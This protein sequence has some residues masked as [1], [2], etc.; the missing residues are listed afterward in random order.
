M[1]TIDTKFVVNAYG[2]SAGGVA[3]HFR[4]LVDGKDAGQASVSATTPTAYTFTTAVEAGQAHK[5]QVYYDNDAYVSGQ[6]RNLYVK[7]IV[8]NGNTMLPTQATYDRYALDGQDTMAGQEGM[9]WEGALNFAT[10]SSYYPAPVV[11]LPPTPTPTTGASTIVVNALG[12]TAGGVNAHFN[13][14]VD[15]VKVGEAT[16]GTT[17]RD[18][19][20]TANATAD[21]A[22]KVQIQYDNDA[23]INGQDRNLL[24]NKITINGHA[25]AP[26]D[27][28][29]TYDKG[30]LDGKDVVAGQSGMWW[31]GTLV[32]GADKTFFPASSGGTT[33]PPAPTPTT[34]SLSVSNV[35]VQ[36]P[37][38]GSATGIAPGYLHTS[39]GQ[40]VDSAGHDV[41]LTGVNWFGAEGYAFVPQGLWIDSYQ[42][43]MDNMK[44]LG[45]NTIRLPWSDA[46]LDGG[47]RMPTGIDYSKNP[48]LVGLNALQVFDKIIQYADK[49]GMKIILD[50]H[51]SDDG[52]SANE[53]G[54]WYTS[55]HPE[56]TMIANWKMLAARYANNSSVIG[57]D[58]H[59]EPHGPA[60]WGDNNTATDWA[61]AAERIG[62]AVQSVNNKLLLFVEGVEQYQGNT[63]WWGGNLDGQ[64][65][66]DV[67]FNTPDQLVYSVHDYPPS[68]AGFGWFN[69]SSYPNNMPA[70]WTSAW[71]RLIQNDQHPVLVGEFGTRLEQY[72]DQQWLPK[73]VQYMDGDWN[74]DGKIDLTNGQ[75]GASWTYWAWS[76]GS[77]D[78]GGILKSDYTVDYNKVNAIKPA[79]FDGATGP[80]STDALFTVKLSAASTTAVSVNYATVDGTAK[81]GSDYTA[82]NGTLTFNPGE[83]T[84]T[85]AVKVLGDSVAEG[86]ETFSL[87]LSAATAATLG[88]DTGVGTI[89]Q[90]ATAAAAQSDVY[91][92]LVAQ[93]APAPTTDAADLLAHTATMSYAADIHHVDVLPDLTE[94]HG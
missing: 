4:L 79:M 71:G 24:V 87:K 84:K 8:V 76:P 29:V 9:W 11:S 70:K 39:G 2:Q 54:L 48:D 53:N 35:T 89:T 40:I 46:M 55:A 38:A 23:Y 82:T 45:F 28:I 93:A 25:V 59:N 27:S 58:L 1:A 83:T 37:A 14:L 64:K 34:P 36:E 52:A 47:G 56:S 3:P 51:R 77:G 68:M 73:L 49:T 92:H 42:H 60:T 10:P 43:H 65:N 19:S 18:Y 66:Y 85:V 50:H 33:T 74:G 63:Y 90:A 57:A 5:V 75:Q 88:T 41:K 94:Y 13:V 80:G 81:A 31:G 22:H 26:T 44:S 91:T 20:F 32:V 7:S 30:A 15:G 16:A 61:H 67:H 6:D 69:D 86:T 12:T 62:N 17:A 78:T 72:K 21:A